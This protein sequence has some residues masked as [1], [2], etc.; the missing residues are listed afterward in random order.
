MAICIVLFYITGQKNLKEQALC[1]AFAAIMLAAL[2]RE[3]NN[4]FIDEIFHG[5]WSAMVIIILLVAAWYIYK[6]YTSIVNSAY[7]FIRRPGY[8]LMLTGFL[9]VFVFSRLFGLP[10]MWRTILKDD[11]QNLPERVAEEGTEV[12]GYSFILLG[13]IDYAVQVS[14]MKMKKLKYNNIN[15]LK[16]NAYVEA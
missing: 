2:I 7:E 14:M 9:I 15:K 12:L 13:T 8:G 10:E 5:A 11:Y 6:H 3:F 1:N 4:Y 16:R